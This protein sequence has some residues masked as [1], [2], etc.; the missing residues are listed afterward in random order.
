MD[1]G[2]SAAICS[3]SKKS[4][5]VVGQ[6]LD[7]RWTWDCICNHMDLLALLNTHTIR[8][9]VGGRRSQMAPNNTQACLTYLAFKKGQPP[10]SRDSWK[11]IYMHT[12]IHAYIYICICMYIA[13]KIYVQIMLNRPATESLESTMPEKQC[14]FRSDRSTSGMVF[15]TRKIRNNRRSTI[16]WLCAQFVNPFDTIIWKVICTHPLGRL[17]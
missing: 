17:E 5:S 7:R 6:N 8:N 1:S 4:Q 11:T 9:G 15:A 14:G 16:G 10:M 12:Y 2:V 3:P 13:V